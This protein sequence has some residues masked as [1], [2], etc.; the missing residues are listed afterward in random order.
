MVAR[1]SAA[2][3]WFRED[4]RLADNPALNAAS[5]DGQNLI[6]VYVH[7]E[8]GSGLRPAGGAAKWWLHHALVA[9]DRSLAAKGGGLCIFRGDAHEII[10]RLARECHACGVYWN[11]RYDEAGRAI[12]AKIKDALKERGVEAKSFSAHLLHEPWTILNKSGAPFRVFSAYWR[13]ALAMGDPEPPIGVPRRLSFQAPAEAMLQQ[14]IALDDLNLL[15]RKPDWA[16]GLRDTWEPGET[17]GHQVLGQFL[18]TR[19]SHYAAGRDRPDDISTSQLSPYLRFGHLSPRQIWHAAMHPAALERAKADAKNIVKFL[20]ELGWREFSY[21]L[22][23]Y[24][25]DLATANLQPRFDKMPWR[26]DPQALQAWQRGQ[27]GYPIVDAGMRELWQTGW[28]HNRVRMV[29]ASFLAKHLLIDWREGEAWFWDTLVDADPASNAAS[30]QWVA[31]S[32]ADAAPYF[33]VF[34]PILQGEKFDPDGAYVRRFVPE[35]ARLPA[36]FIHKPWRA[37][38]DALAQAG[39]DLGKTYPLPI[40]AH[41][42][43]RARALAAFAE[44]GGGAD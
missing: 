31:G 28:M 42:E 15:P 11:R 14:A 23:Y 6:C 22:L 39:V 25:P 2:I 24:N 35:L 17:A 30:W 36:A 37:S 19:L 38:A 12:D 40:V 16:G 29:V 18:R 1:A 32:G 5:A 26:S 3:L 7:D 9:L 8:T 21:Q 41:E 10:T 44:I 34:N 4:L 33:R 43:G 27:T 20:S 13:A